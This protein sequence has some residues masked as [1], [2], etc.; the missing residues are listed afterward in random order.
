MFIEQFN[1]FELRCHGPLGR[2][3]N[4]KTGY[5]QGKT[6][7]SKENN[8]SSELLLTAKYIAEGNVSCFPS[9]GPSQLY[10]LS[11][12]R[13]VLNVNLSKGRIEQFNFYN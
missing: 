4:S 2:T 6:K 5:F 11:K 8:S 1:E 7:V 9:L 10:K 12:K 13:Y 3:C